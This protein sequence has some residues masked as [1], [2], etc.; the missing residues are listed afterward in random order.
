MTRNLLF[1]FVII[2]VALFIG[3]LGYHCLAKLPWISSFENAAMI[4]SG[5]GPVDDLP[6]DGSKIFAGCYAI[7]SGVMFLVVIGI[8]FAPVIH[9]AFHKFH[10]A[11]DSK[12]K[13]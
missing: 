4:L 10:L 12:F 8:V 7:F 5:M 13:N 6:N 1:G 11:E 2:I 3:I 9:R